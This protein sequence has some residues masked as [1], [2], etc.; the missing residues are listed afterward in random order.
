MA[1]QGPKRRRVSKEQMRLWV[2]RD[3]MQQK[4]LGRRLAEK[5]RASEA[6]R[7]RRVGDPVAIDQD[8]SLFAYHGH[9]TKVDSAKSIKRANSLAR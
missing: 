2:Q 6:A 9:L 1:R 8:D 5:A 4:N 3:L 7:R